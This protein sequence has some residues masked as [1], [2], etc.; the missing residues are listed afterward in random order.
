MSLADFMLP[1]VAVSDVDLR[2][3]ALQALPG[4]LFAGYDPHSETA[5]VNGSV[6]SATSRAQAFPP[7][8]YKAHRHHNFLATLPDG[9]RAPVLWDMEDAR[10]F[11]ALTYFG[12]PLNVFQYCRRRGDR[13]AVLWRL[14]AYFEPSRNVGHPGV[15]VD[16]DLTF[17]EKQPTVFWR[18]AIAGSRWLDPHRRVSPL[19]IG[20]AD[21]F[22]SSAR[23]YSRIR[24]VL[25]ARASAVLDLKFTGA[26]TGTRPWLVDLDVVGEHTTPQQQLNH[27][28]LLCPNGNDV[29]SGLYWVLQTNSVAFR[30]EC[31]YE[32]VPDYFLRPWVHY[33]PVA[34]GLT[35]LEEKYAFCEANPD[36]CL[37]IIDNAQAAYA[38]MTDTNVWSTAEADVLTRLGLS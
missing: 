8:G 13:H 20:S 26:F 22:V 3:L 4:A 38:A 12:R 19:S 7:D 21:E 23:H 5:L 28:Y 29:A 17:Q 10:A 15:I 1:E 2:E 27:R 32:V 11:D 18:G 9:L 31:E 30:E 25:E 6:V 35:D 14:R 34:R 16:D 36:L 37:R 33:V 24:A